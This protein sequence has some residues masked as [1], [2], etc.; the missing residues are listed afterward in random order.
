MQ[1]LDHPR[2]L[3]QY[4]H[5]LPLSWIYYDQYQKKN[6]SQLSEVSH[7]DSHKELNYIH[8]DVINHVLFF[9]HQLFL[10]FRSL[11]RYVLLQSSHILNTTLT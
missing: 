4:N 10:L 2:Q 7:H 11:I 6:G 5:H 8:W 1:N 9:M 3:L